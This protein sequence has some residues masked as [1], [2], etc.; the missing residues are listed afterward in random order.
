M[1][2]HDR[3]P[4]RWG[5]LPP[6]SPSP[7]LALA[8][9]VLS[10]C[11]GGGGGASSVVN[12]PPKA[13]GPR[14]S[15]SVVLTSDDKRLLVVN[16]D[17][18]TVTILDVSQVQPRETCQLA[19]GGDP[20]SVAVTSRG[21]KAYVANAGS[22]TVSVLSLGT[23]PHVLRTIP[24]GTEPRAVLIDD[25]DRRAFVANSGSNEIS[26]I[27]VATDQVVRT[28]AI[29]AG[30]GQAPRALAYRKDSG[31]ERL[32]AA[33]FFGELRPGRTGLD[34]PQDDSRE[35][36][37]AVFDAAA[38][39]FVASVA[40][41][42]TAN[43]G[44]NS[45]G[46]VLDRIGTENGV[47]GVDA[48][49]PVNPA[50][51][52]FATGAYPNQLASIGVHPT[53]GKAYVVS[54][55]ASP[56]G[57]FGFNF[58]AQGLVSVF[59]LATNAEVTADASAT[60]HQ[61]APLN[62]NQGL[63]Q[64]TATQP[65]IFQT[66]PIAIAFK[67]DGSEAW[68]AIQNSD[69]LVRMTVDTNGLP[70]IGAPVQAGAAS[71]QRVDLHETE[72][73]GIAGKAPRGLALDSSGARAYVH[74][75]VSRSISVVDTAQ[76]KVIATALCAPVPA[77]GTPDATVQL[78]A[79]LFF[80]GRGP[81]E[82]MS[83]ESWGA[84]AVCHPDGLADGVTWMFPAGPRQTIPLDGMFSRFHVG[85][86]RILNWS[87]LR[88]E[89]QDFEL[90]TRNVFGGRGL[91][92][93]D[94]V[95]F[96]AGGATGATPAD[97]AALTRFHQFLNAAGTDNP[98]AGDAALPALLGARRDF[99]MATLWDGR[100]VIAGGRSGA[101]DG[102]LIGG[103]D[104]VLLFDPKAN[105]ITRR[106]ATGFTPR[107]SFGLVAYDGGGTIRVL[108]VGGYTATAAATAPT[109]SVQEY[110]LVTDTWR[111]VA[112]L[113][114]ATAEFGI[115]VNGPLNVGEPISE[116]NVLCGNRGST[117][118]PNVTGALMRYT[119]D[120]VGSGAWRT[121]SFSFTARRNLGGAAIV[122]GV[123]PTH[124]FAVGG[125]DGAGNALATVEAFAA[126]TS[127]NAPTNPTA[128]VTPLTALPAPRHSLAIGTAVNRILVFGGVD[129]TG[130]ETATTF[131]YN[132]AV[133]GAVAGP[134]GVPSG[135]WVA[136]ANLPAAVR[137][138]QASNPQPVANFLATK[139][140]QRDARQDAIA[141][142]VKRA[143]RSNVAPNRGV[144]GGASGGAVAAGAALF[145][146]PGLTGVADVS[147]ATCHGGSKWTRSI[148]DFASPPSP[149]LA[150]GF[151]EVRGAEL[152]RTKAQPAT[153]FDVGTFVPFSAGRNS[154]GRFNPSDVGQRI[155]ALGAA[156]FNIPSLLSVH[157]T[158]PYFHHG[159]AQTLDEVLGG[160][161]DQNGASPFKGVHHVPNATQRANLI[162]FLRAI[163]ETTPIFP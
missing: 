99:G 95:L 154:E 29:D 56:N 124:V 130:A 136:R 63:K 150:R 114:V 21:D 145:A 47:G 11:G 35:G 8:L 143:V 28:L 20:R 58:N 161:H 144:S 57:P 138:A 103:A 19:V 36:R 156:G 82:R 88:D 137:S 151:E 34:A 49:D 152:R 60:V 102:T 73:G 42:P 5:A 64:D 75:F 90:N 126:T 158:A 104:T 160:A 129:A 127:Q 51:N 97:S 9:L 117:Q 17:T 81:D 37:I 41:A 53:N 61:K 101:G 30:V 25:G 24:V 135:V 134:P 121:L 52:G 59:D 13:F 98:L 142:W 118:T 72:A 96:L 153:L 122:R 77:P 43:T 105:T 131:E 48:P 159:I 40:L 44:F 120:P 27:D 85:D 109:A 32:L 112:P 139:S 66:N 22:G 93:D 65:V 110:D 162:E 54:T 111:N 71:I 12:P 84:C 18:D 125:R 31:G 123:F 163:D 62:L 91:I 68:I 46:S 69:L 10:A 133:N 147:C 87:A 119:P 94:R 157:Q 80:S 92:D 55:A 26:V 1:I 4:C 79:E 16:P 15:S 76:R 7:S 45:N 78:G 141:E 38:L 23:P 148:V 113:P 116:V 115:A 107:H 146:Q 2:D 14:G 108:A 83:S 67:A 89:N 155:N 100:I 86:Q 106:S 128:A 74:N 132:A 33:M 3:K 50:Q 6:L 140:A 149:D 39:T 70:T